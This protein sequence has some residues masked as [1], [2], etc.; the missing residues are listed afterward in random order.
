MTYPNKKII[1]PTLTNGC[2][3]LDV[4]RQ[5]IQKRIMNFSKV[6][7]ILFGANSKNDWQIYGMVK[8]IDVHD[9]QKMLKTIKM[10]GIFLLQKKDDQTLKLSKYV[11]C[12]V[13][14]LKMTSIFWDCTKK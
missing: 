7:V 5:S 14:C 8:K 11:F 2:H 3:F 1:M 9:G 6:W 13:R 10:I 12:M 4:Q